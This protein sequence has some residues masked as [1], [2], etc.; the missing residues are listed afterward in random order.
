MLVLLNLLSGVALLTYGIYLVKSGVLRVFG[1]NLNALVAKTLQSKFWPVRA[2]ATGVGITALVQSSNATALLVSSF[3]AKGVLSLTPALIIMLGADLGSALMARI[4]TFD[5][6]WLAPLFFIVGINLFL[7]KKSTKIGKI[8]R[9]LIGLGIVLLALKTIV[10]TTAPLSQSETMQLILSSLDGEY[11]LAVIV[12]ALLAMICYSSLAAVLITAML[13]SHDALSLTTALYLVI[14]ANLGSCALEILG[15]ISQGLSAKRVMFG[16]LFFKLTISLGCFIYLQLS[17]KLPNFLPLNELV[18]WFHVLFNF[19][20]CFLLAPFTH[21]YGQLLLK[22]FPDPKNQEAIEDNAPFFLD[23]QSLENPALATSN[24]IREILRIGGFLHEM[25]NLFKDSLT[26]KTGH[27]QKIANLSALIDKLCAEVK[28]YITNI[29]PASRDHTQRW[30]QCLAAIMACIQASDLLR[31]LQEQISFVNHSQ[32]YNL[33]AHGRADLIK[34][35]TLVNEDLSLTL[36]ALMTGQDKEIKA[37]F[38]HKKQFKEV[39]DRYSL[40]Q[41]N[42][43][44][45]SDYATDTGA[46]MLNIIADLRQLNGCFVAMAASTHAPNLENLEEKET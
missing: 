2:M 28:N 43:L 26:G 17:L 27:S 24:A 40:K 42:H 6:S 35:T 13:A 14:G 32:E 19:A 22:I 12:G 34:L 25:L 45:N 46:I 9:I 16:N 10:S 37:V 4:L 31:R 41:L 39:S 33:T 5:L 29:E 15:A 20:V 30:N 18:I 21:F 38:E 11:T 8:G 36:N 23:E 44:S 1:S 7:H 3:L